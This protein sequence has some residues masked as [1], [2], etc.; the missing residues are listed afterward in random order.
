MTQHPEGAWG[1]A[2]GT[3]DLVG[4]ARLDEG[5][6]RCLIHPHRQYHITGVKSSQTAQCI[7]GKLG[8]KGPSP[9][10]GWTLTDGAGVCSHN[11]KHSRTDSRTHRIV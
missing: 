9:E 7:V 11:K 2:E 3:R 4:R 10:G 5:G 1:E 8:A 6:A